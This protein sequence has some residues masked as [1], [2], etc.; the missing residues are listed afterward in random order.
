MKVYNYEKKFASKSFCYILI[1]DE[2]VLVLC[3]K[4]PF[5]IINIYD[6]T[7]LS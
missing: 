1:M 6:Q 5:L 4:W 2:K 7:D 3:E